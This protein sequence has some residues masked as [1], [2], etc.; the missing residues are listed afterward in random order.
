MCT[1]DH[2]LHP[3]TIVRSLVSM[4]G[5]WHDKEVWH[6][7]TGK[8]CG[9]GGTHLDDILIWCKLKLVASDI[10]G[11]LGKG[12]QLGTIKDILEVEGREGSSWYTP[13]GDGVLTT[14]L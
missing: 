5:A 4:E 2:R 10:D 8:G 7:T 13:T 3:L 12:A 11:N 14:P 1:R 9:V 6:V